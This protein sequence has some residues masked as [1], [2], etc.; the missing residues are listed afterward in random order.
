MKNLRLGLILAAIASLGLACQG[1]NKIVNGESADSAPSQ[2]GDPGN[3]GGSGAG[4]IHGIIYLKGGTSKRL[5]DSK[6]QIIRADGRSINE[7]TSENG[8]F[9]VAGLAPGAYVIRPVDVE[10]T[11]VEKQTVDVKASQITEVVIIYSKTLARRSSGLAAAVLL[12]TCPGPGPCTEQPYPDQRFKIERID[13]LFE[14]TAVTDRNGLIQVSLE[15]G[16]YHVAKVFDNGARIGSCPER[17]VTVYPALH[18]FERIVCD[19]GM[20]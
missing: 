15:P 12:R 20:R 3:S 8:E 7:A 11:T 5:F 18:T 19:S 14:T 13:G 1:V 9:T 2:A 10:G 6:V 17:N 4:T 16:K